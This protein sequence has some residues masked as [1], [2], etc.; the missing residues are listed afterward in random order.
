LDSFNFEANPKLEYQRR[1]LLIVAPEFEAK[2]VYLS[3]IG[4][5]Y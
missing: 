4:Y 1:T 3:I 2:E 5:I